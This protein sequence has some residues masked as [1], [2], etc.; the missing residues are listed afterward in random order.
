MVNCKSLSYRTP[1]TKESAIY[2]LKLGEKIVLKDPRRDSFI[3]CEYNPFRT[4]DFP[5]YKLDL[6]TITEIKNIIN[7]PKWVAFIAYPIGINEEDIN[8]T[9][10]IPKRL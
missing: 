1:L 9:R 10:N 4:L 8:D 6:L 3:C 7:F 2:Y 5:S